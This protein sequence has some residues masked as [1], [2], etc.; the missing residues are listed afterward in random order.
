MTSRCT[1][2][3]DSSKLALLLAFSPKFTKNLQLGI[4]WLFKSSVKVSKKDDFSMFGIPQIIQSEKQLIFPLLFIILR[5]KHRA[6]YNIYCR[7]R[8]TPT[9]GTCW[10][11]I[12]RQTWWKTISGHKSHTSVS[13]SFHTPLEWVARLT[14]DAEMR[15][16][17]TFF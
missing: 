7:L 8:E 5:H 10:F 15:E 4:M 17:S 9:S 16:N 1:V 12:F 2:Y 11:W 6:R 13:W 14:S 3:M